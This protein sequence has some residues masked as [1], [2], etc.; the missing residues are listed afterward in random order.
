MQAIV[1]DIAIIE[2]ITGSC[3]YLH[4]FAIAH[5]EPTAEYSLNMKYAKIHYFL[6]LYC[7]TFFYSKYTNIR[8]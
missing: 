4:I 3:Y 5:L 6:D 7:L 1:S 2:H 8:Y